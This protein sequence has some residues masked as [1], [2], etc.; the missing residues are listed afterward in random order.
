M[1]AATRV[2]RGPAPPAHTFA[3]LGDGVPAVAPPT[4]VAFPDLVES[5]PAAPPEP[6]DPAET[7]DEGRQVGR[8][9]RDAEVEA[10]QAEVDRLQAALADAEAAAAEADGL[11]AEAVA[12]AAERLA[13]LWSDAVREMQPTMASIA[14]EAAEALLAAP[15]SEPQQAAAET[16]IAE[17]VDA[18]AADGPVVVALH[19]VDLL[20]LQEAGLAASLTGAHPGLRWEPDAALA[21]SDWTA[22]TSEATIRRVRTDMVAS[23]RARLGL[24]PA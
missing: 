21:E 13:V 20:R 7:F 8:T 19:P 24:T 9:D 5:E 14:I 15:L 22:T 23:L 2:L 11:R 12:E 16:A 17:A 4:F 3:A 6:P 18:L 1:T 10:L